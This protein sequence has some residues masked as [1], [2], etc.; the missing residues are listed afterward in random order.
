MKKV[1][2]VCSSPQYEHMWES[3]GWEVTY[4]IK[5]ADVVQFTGGS[6]VTP[7]LYG[8]ERNPH[9][10]NDEMRDEMELSLYAQALE[11]G[12]PMVGIC[13]G[14]QFLNV[15]NGGKMYQHC[16]GHATG[17]NHIVVDV[18]TNEEV[19]CS[20]THHQLMIANPAKGFVVAVANGLSYHRQRSNPDTE[21][22]FSILD[23]E[24]VY[25]PETRSLCFQPHPE[26]DAD[27]ACAAYY[28]ELMDR[29]KLLGN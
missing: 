15:A 3:Q 19:E 13:R 16:E 22:C 2:I 12:I 4:S 27:G 7:L 28:F 29:Y 20:S 17:R 9:T 14:G 25:Y 23:T 5:K 6:D 1:C 18:T 11:K 10:G 24:V 8:E 21:D 26:F